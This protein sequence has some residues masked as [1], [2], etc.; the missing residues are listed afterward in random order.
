M[1]GLVPVDTRLVQLAAQ[2][3][4]FLL[5]SAMHSHVIAVL[6]A[7]QCRQCRSQARA[8]VGVV[9]G[10]QESAWGNPLTL[11]HIKLL[12]QPR[13]WGVGFKIDLGFDFAIRGNCAFQFAA[14]HNRGSYRNPRACR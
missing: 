13:K 8:G 12:D 11:M 4:P 10:K 3:K 7:F 6:G 5:R 1:L 14:R 9:H 2:G